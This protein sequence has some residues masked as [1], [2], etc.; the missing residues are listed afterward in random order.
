MNTIDQ[1]NPFDKAQWIGGTTTEGSPV[2]IRHFNAA[3]VHRAVLFVTGLGY[4]EAQ[5]N[6]VLVS[7]SKYIPVFSNYE[8]RPLEKFLYPLHDEMTH[9]IYYYQYDVTSLILEGDNCL[10]IQLGN[11]WYRQMERNIEGP[12]HFGNELKTIYRLELETESETYTFCSDGSE[13]WHESE[14]VYSNLFIGEVIDPT[15]VKSEKPVQILPA[16]QTT[17]RKEMG[18]VDKVI[19]RIT[20]QFLGK[21]DGRA[22]FDAGENISGVVRIYTSAPKGTEIRLR[23]A[24][25]L[26][27]NM[28]L[29]FSTTV[30]SYLCSSG[31]EQIMMDVFISDGTPRTFEP[32]FVWHAFRYFDVEGDFDTAEVLVIHSDTPVTATFESPSEGLQFLFDAFLRTQLNNMHSC[33]PSDCPHRERV[34]Y[35]GDGQVCAPA[36]MMMLDSQEFYRKWIQDILDCQDKKTGHV[37]HSAP[38]NGGGGGPGGWGCSIVLVPYTYYKQFGEVEVLKK[39]YKPMRHWIQYLTN[40]M[41]NGLVTHEEDGGWCL[42]DW[43]TLEKTCIPEPFVNTC[44]LIKSLHHLTEIAVVLE[45]TEDVSEY[46]TLIETASKAIRKVYYNETNGH[47]CDGVQGADAYAIWASITVGQEAE[48]LAKELAVTYETLNHFDT[49]FL[50]TDILMEVLIDYGYADVALQL[51]ESEERGAF[52][53]QKRRGATTLWESW[54]GIEYDGS[55]I[56]HAHPMFGACVRQLFTGFLGIRQR[57]GTAGY[58][59]VEISPCIPQKLTYAKGSIHTPQGEISVGWT[60]NDGK[61]EFHIS[62]PESMNVI[63]KKP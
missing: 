4:F 45:C 36:A 59:N 41:E 8:P 21:I 38:F 16:P 60:K 58:T 28:S 13:T 29:D 57:I 3:N 50:G 14:I 48:K 7:D 12:V 52:L 46:T 24:E 15:T 63:F 10:T 40:H 26:H 43:Y 22:V 35:T 54:D 37:Q 9:C 18:T 62:V 23:F 32:K 53:Y 5:I 56:S 2:I 11:G 31:R 19:R 47:Y 42:G 55:N 20:P 6:N 30:P 1:K 17:F 39:C 61:T 49:G 34:G 27:T 33:V 44:Y 51:L 25:E